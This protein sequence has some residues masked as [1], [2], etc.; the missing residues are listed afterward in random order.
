M[1]GA[2]LGVERDPPTPG[3]LREMLA[4][5]R[6]A[7]TTGDL[8]AQAPGWQHRPQWRI[9][10]KRGALYK[11]KLENRFAAGPHAGHDTGAYRH[12]YTTY[13]GIDRRR[14]ANDPGAGARPLTGPVGMMLFCPVASRPRP[15][16]S[17]RMQGRRTVFEQCPM[18]WPAQCSRFPPPAGESWRGVR[19]GPPEG[20]SVPSMDR[21]SRRQHAPCPSRSRRPSAPSPGRLGRGSWPPASSR[22]EHLTEPATTGKEPLP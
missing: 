22:P 10:W 21:A 14:F 7:W 3:E 11:I 18:F 6:D 5:H 20:R 12:K 13:G 4:W 19:S 8:I 15:F 9:C 1:P 16:P 2:G 17:P